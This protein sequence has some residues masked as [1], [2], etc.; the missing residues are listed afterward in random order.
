MAAYAV[1]ANRVTTLPAFPLELV[2]EFTKRWWVRLLR[3]L[4]ARLVRTQRKPGV[5]EFLSPEHKTGPYS[6]LVLALD[7]LPVARVLRELVDTAWA[8]RVL[9]PRTKA[10][11]FAIVA[12]GVGSLRAEREAIQL[13]AE[14][15]LAGDQIEVILSHLSSPLLDPAE[16]VML[17]LARESIRYDHAQIQ[18]QALAVSKELT[19]EQ[20]VE[21]IGV[22]GLANLV[23][24]LEPICGPE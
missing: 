9:A 18:R 14:Q 2:E 17:P 16:K 4:L 10:L 13:L 22:I 3:P 21:L 20:F 15:G 12:R 5:R 24:R 11:V 8:S 23:C 7:G 19:Q 6:Y 1:C